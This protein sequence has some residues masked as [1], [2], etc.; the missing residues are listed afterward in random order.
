MRSPERYA[1]VQEFSFQVEL[2]EGDV[3]HEVSEERG[4]WKI[5]EKTGGAHPDRG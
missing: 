5:S 4:S 1:R 3:L 2:P